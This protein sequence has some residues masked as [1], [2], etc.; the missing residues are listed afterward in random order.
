MLSLA[1]NYIVIFVIIYFTIFCNKYFF[2]FKNIFFFTSL[3]LHLASTIVYVKMFPTGDWETFMWSQQEGVAQLSLNDI[4]F[5]SFRTSNLVITII[6]ILKKI[7]IFSNFSI[8]LLFS[9]ISFFGI[10]IFIQNIIKLGLEKKIAYWLLFIP[11]MHFW[12]SIVGKDSLLIFFLSFFFYFYIDRKIIL[13]I[14]FIF[15]VWMI[16]PHIGSLFL[17]SIILTQFFLV[18]GYK[19]KITIFFTLCI[20]FIALV[21]IPI[22][23]GY[24]LSN[25]DGLTNNLFLQI[26]SQFS[27]LAAKYQTSGSYYQ[28]SNILSNMFN[29]VMFPSSYL[30]NSKSIIIDLVILGE[31]VTFIYIAFLISNHKKKVQVD[32]KIIYFLLICV[33]FYLLTMPQILFNFGLN[34]RQKWMILPFIIYLSFVLKN[35]F[36]SKNKI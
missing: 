34:I 7:L 15:F 3:F 29:Y 35:L 22:T 32:K 2:Q 5:S 12:T 19:F 17:I 14:I 33:F 26:L 6:F 24:F 9:I 36:V 10:L 30:F 31:I 25:S 27:E 13:S 16:R 23:K 28:S 11:G 1:Y 8:I 20:T 21:N 18:K 4:S